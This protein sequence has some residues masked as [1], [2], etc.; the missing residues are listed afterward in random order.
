MKIT[1]KDGTLIE[2]SAEETL[3]LVKALASAEVN[4]VSNGKGR[5]VIC[6]KPITASGRYLLCGDPECTRA[7]NAWH[8][9]RYGARK[10]TEKRCPDC[11]NWIKTIPVI[12]QDGND[13]EVEKGHDP[14]CPQNVND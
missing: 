1:L 3:P 2:R 12:G 6:H 7:R 11:G 10:K 9:R 13:S 14:N 4:E 8:A 5:C